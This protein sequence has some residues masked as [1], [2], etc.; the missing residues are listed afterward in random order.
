MPFDWT[1]DAYRN[2]HASAEDGSAVTVS[3]LPIH[4]RESWTYAWSNFDGRVLI[5][6]KIYGSAGEAK[7]WV[8]ELFAGL[9]IAA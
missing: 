3:R 6:T 9:E 5:G 2:W 1:Q 8:E 7:A 4:A